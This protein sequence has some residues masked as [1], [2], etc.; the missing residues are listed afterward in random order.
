[1]IPYTP[2][3]I[4]V[5]VPDEEELYNYCL[6]NSFSKSPN[7][8]EGI[9][10]IV[11]SKEE[12]GDWRT[13]LNAYNGLISDKGNELLAKEQDTR[14]YN[15]VT[16]SN[17]LGSFYFEPTFKRQFPELVEACLKLPFKNLVGVFL[18]LA[19]HRG[20]AIHKDPK[21]V[22]D[23]DSISTVPNR[24]N[25]SLN[26]FENPKFF[27]TDGNEKIY[28]KVTREYPCFAFDN[29]N[30]L[31]GADPSDKESIRRMQLLIYGVLDEEK[32]KELLHRSIAKWTSK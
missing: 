7:L 20:S 18:L 12:L 23:D 32:H 28:M 31:H 29:E 26:C 21:P 14:V 9:I 3:D 4:Q 19:G 30:Y 15:I 16:S 6:S 8:E 17:N 25:I 27:I 22:L 24:Y 5:T 11:G 2:I 10:C 13:T 1:M